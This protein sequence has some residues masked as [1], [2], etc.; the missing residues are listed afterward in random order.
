M[1]AIAVKTNDP[2]T[3]INAAMTGVIILIADWDK[4]NDNCDCNRD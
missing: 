1:I 2:M 3:L 4:K